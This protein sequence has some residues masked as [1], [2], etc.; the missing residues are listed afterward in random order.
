MDDAPECQHC[1]QPVTGRASYNGFRLCYPSPEE[2]RP[3]CYYLVAI[4]HHHVP[5]DR[6]EC[7]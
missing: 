3:N 4:D 6:E 5:C 2:D 1:H 7:Q